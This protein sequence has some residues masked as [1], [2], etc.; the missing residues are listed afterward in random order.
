MY[1][2]LVQFTFTDAGRAHAKAIAPFIVDAIKQ[3]PGCLSALFFSDATD[4]RSGLCV[5][6]ETQEHADKAAAVMSPQLE[7]HLAGKIE[8]PPDRRLFPVLAS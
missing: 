5:Q 2:R 6:W 7:M 4:G 3:Q 1:L 8:G